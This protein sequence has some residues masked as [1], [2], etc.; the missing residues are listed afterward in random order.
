MHVCLARAELREH[1]ADTMCLFGRQEDPWPKAE[2]GEGRAEL[3]E[4]R[5]EQGLGWGCTPW[6][7]RP[8]ELALHLS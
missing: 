5:V 6:F 2:F 7:E 4:G 8:P 1:K 3:G